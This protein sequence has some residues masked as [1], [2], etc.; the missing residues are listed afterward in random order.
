MQEVI[1]L[2][3]VT[4][5]WSMVPASLPA[6]DKHVLPTAAEAVLTQEALLP[7]PV[8]LFNCPKLPRRK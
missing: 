1:L 4:A 8:V 5:S 3:C 2:S 7:E 6:T